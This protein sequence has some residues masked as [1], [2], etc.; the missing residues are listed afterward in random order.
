MKIIIIYLT[1]NKVSSRGVIFANYRRE[2]EVKTG[3]F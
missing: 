1:G 3:S 2:G